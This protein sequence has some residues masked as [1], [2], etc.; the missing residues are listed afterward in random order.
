MRN[1]GNDGVQEDDETDQMFDWPQKQAGDDHKHRRK[2][3]E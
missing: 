3:T 1:E 2:K